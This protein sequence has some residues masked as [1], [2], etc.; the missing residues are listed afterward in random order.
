MSAVSPIQIRDLM[1]TIPSW[2][3]ML[4]NMADNTLFSET[5]MDSL[6][7]L[8]LVSEIQNR[9]GVEI[10]DDDVQHIS[11]IADIARYLCDRMQ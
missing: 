7:L 5:G 11:T 9:Y 4:P 6:A 10:S 1:E 2:A 8:E 3:R